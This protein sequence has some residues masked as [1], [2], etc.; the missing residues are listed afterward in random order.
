MNSILIAL[1]LLVYFLL[2][3][4]HIKEANLKHEALV[5]P[6]IR[7]VNVREVWNNSPHNAFTD[8]TNYNNTFILAFREGLDHHSFDG[9]IR[10]LSSKNDR[11]WKSDTL[12]T[13]NDWDLRDVKFIISAKNV[14][15]LN[16]VARKQSANV[17]SLKSVAWYLDDQKK[18]NGPIEDS[19][20]ENTWRWG[21]AE[22]QDKI[23]TVA[24]AGK[25]R[26]GCL[27]SSKD[28]HSWNVERDTVFPDLSSYPNE[29]A[30]CI[31]SDSTAVCLLRR[32]AGSKT[33]LIGK[34]RYPFHSWEWHDLGIR[35]GGPRMLLLKNGII[36]ATVRLYN[37][38]EHTS[39]CWVDTV[40]NKLVELDKLPSG[41]D[42][43][44]AGMVET[45]RQLL[46]S[47]YS[48]HIGKKA[49][50]YLAKIKLD[51]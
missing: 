43:G 6:G 20:A 1:D 10:I 26:Q 3:D 23:Y 49:T 12:I 42:N 44:Y 47:Y 16:A 5:P 8:I 46:I 36:L 35:I 9:K 17:N 19:A 48:S 29:A 30:L 37:E 38:S 39:V 45:K 31:T 14:L 15:Y 40:T 41:G 7:S 50:I 28:E 27:Y 11:R 25:N 21:W 34:S 32:E 18:W 51:Y 2:L 33:G 4:F 13:L 24:Y 22:F